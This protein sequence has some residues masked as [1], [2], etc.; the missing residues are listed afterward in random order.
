MYKLI[1]SMVSKRLHANAHVRLSRSKRVSPEPY[2]TP[3][4]TLIR[5]PPPFPAGPVLI[6]PERTGPRYCSHPL[7]CIHHNYL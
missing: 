6:E 2:L 5:P 4:A 1:N 7:K 3:Y